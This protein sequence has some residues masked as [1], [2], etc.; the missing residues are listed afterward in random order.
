MQERPW[1]FPQEGSKCIGIHHW[2]TRVVVCYHWYLWD[3]HIYGLIPPSCIPQV[4]IAFNRFIAALYY[5]EYDGRKLEAL[6]ERTCLTL[7]NFLINSVTNLCR[8]I[9]IFERVENK[10]FV[11][12]S[13][14]VMDAV[15]KYA[16]VPVK[17]Q[18]HAK[19]QSYAKATG[20]PS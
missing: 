14:Q 10:G 6:D 13:Q 2:W 5:Y 19:A 16:M 7:L 17:I 4:S 1:T 9:K 11:F 18:S 20:T 15:L 8:H 3:Y 12:T